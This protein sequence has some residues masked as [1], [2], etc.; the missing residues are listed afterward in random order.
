MGAL[1][2]SRGHIGA[3]RL[4]ALFGLKKVQPFVGQGCTGK[5][6]RIHQPSIREPGQPSNAQLANINRLSIQLIVRQDKR[7]LDHGDDHCS[8]MSRNC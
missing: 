2:V 6:P 7:A 3:L 8:Q 5:L 4:A 1:T